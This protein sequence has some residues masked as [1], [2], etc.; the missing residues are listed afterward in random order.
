[1]R[2]LLFVP[3]ASAAA[4]VTAGPAA[5]LC[6]PSTFIDLTE[7][8]PAPP[9]VHVRPGSLVSWRS[10]AASPPS[11]IVFGGASC[12]DYP[13]GLLCGFPGPGEYP[14]SVEGFGEGSGIVVVDE[15]DWITLSAPAR[16]VTFGRSAVLR[17]TAFRPYACAP[18]L[19]GPQLRVSRRP[20]GSRRFVRTRRVTLRPGVADAF[21]AWRTRVRPSIGTAY[22]AEWS[23]HASAVARVDVRPRVALRRTHGGL[24][25]TVTSLRGYR[26]RWVAVQRRVGA[27]WRFVRALR[28][29]ARSTAVFRPPRRGVYRVF[30][31]RGTAGPGYVEGFSRPLRSRSPRPGS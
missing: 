3:V 9:L 16:V 2:R 25:T 5:A 20:A 24:R 7:A 10:P 26:G 4:L 23:G 27:R 31:P 6:A 11:R 28:L 13:G 22:R 15:V 18:R 19:G 12:S 1:M 21:E 14:Y 29:G 17:G 8:G 30:V